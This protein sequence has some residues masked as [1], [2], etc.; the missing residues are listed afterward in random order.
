MFFGTQT[1]NMRDMVSK[2]RSSNAKLTLEQVEDIRDILVVTNNQRGM[3]KIL[4][5]YYGV[6][7]TA[8]SN[9]KFG[10]TWK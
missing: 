6:G 10:L 5:S 4:S 2:G 3:N 8:I 7:E 1:D 9:I